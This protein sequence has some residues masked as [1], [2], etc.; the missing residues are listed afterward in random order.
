LG[1]AVFEA[2]KQPVAFSNDRGKKLPAYQVPT[3]KSLALRDKI[4]HPGD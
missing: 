2:E 4:I 1:Q 3:F